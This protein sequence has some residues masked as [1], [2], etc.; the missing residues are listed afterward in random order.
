MKA[1]AVPYQPGWKAELTAWRLNQKLP[2]IAEADILRAQALIEKLIYAQE[3]LQPHEQ[4]VL[5]SVIEQI[6]TNRKSLTV[7]ERL[8]LRYRIAL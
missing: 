8:R 4:R 3:S 6:Y 7:K 5:I 1:L 2:G